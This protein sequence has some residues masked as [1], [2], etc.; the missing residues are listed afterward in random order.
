M[1]DAEWDVASVLR[2]QLQAANAVICAC[3]AELESRTERSKSST[4]CTTAG[5]ATSIEAAALGGAG[6]LVTT[7]LLG[8][9]TLEGLVVGGATF[10]VLQGGSLL[11]GWIF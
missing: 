3:E 9:S 11:A 2:G 10:V 1:I 7:E 5:S 8:G 4:S 6:Y